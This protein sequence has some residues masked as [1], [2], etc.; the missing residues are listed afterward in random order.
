MVKLAHNLDAALQYMFEVA[1]RFG[2]PT[3][4]HAQGAGL[5]VKPLSW[6]QAQH[7]G[8]SI[9]LLQGSLSHMKCAAWVTRL[10]LPLL[11]QKLSTTPRSAMELQGAQM[12]EVAEGIP[13]GLEDAVLSTQARPQ[14][15]DVS[16]EMPEKMSVMVVALAT[17]QLARS[18]VKEEAPENV[19]TKV[20]TLATFHVLKSLVK[21]EAP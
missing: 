4:P 1:H 13:E 2:V 19:V 10:L 7:V 12:S 20:V 17:F 8:A 6:P 16:K 21:E 9:V 5:I 15:V 18:L 3:V 14:R 11:A